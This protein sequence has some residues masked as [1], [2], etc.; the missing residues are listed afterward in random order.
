MLYTFRMATKKLPK[1]LKS[2]RQLVATA[3]EG[4][5]GLYCLGTPKTDDADYAIL[6]PSGKVK[7]GMMGSQG[8]PLPPD[9]HWTW[10]RAKKRRQQERRRRRDPRALVV[11]S[12]TERD[13]ILSISSTHLCADCE[14]D[15]RRRKHSHTAAH[16]NGGYAE[17]LCCRCARG[18][19]ALCVIYI[20]HQRRLA[21]KERRRRR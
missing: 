18:R 11:T 7:R 4:R 13:A 14:R 8:Y 17:P 12:H 3:A 2:G 21:A 9:G 1:R 10:L 5:V 20:R 19:G 6:L 15:V 16:A